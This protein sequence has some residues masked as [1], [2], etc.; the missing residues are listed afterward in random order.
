MMKESATPLLLKKGNITA[1]PILHHTVETAAA[2]C[3]AFKAVDP[4]CVA[5]EIAETMQEPIM[6][7]VER[8][9][10]ISVVIT[11][12]EQLSPLYYLCEPCDGIFEGLRCAMEYGRAA[13]CIDLDV[14]GYPDVHERVPDPYAITI[15]GL[16]KYWYAYRRYGDSRPSPLDERRELQMA[17]RLKE[18]SLRYERV[19]FVG[20]MAHVARVLELVERQAFP[21]LVPARREVAELC[22]LTEASCREVLPEGGYLPVAYEEARKSFLEG[23]ELPFPPDRWHHLLEL[24]SKAALPYTTKQGIAFPGYH[25]RNLTHFVRNYA[26]VSERLSPTLFQ[27]LTAAKSCV[28]HNYAY[29]VWCLATEYPHLRNVDNRA[30]ID[31]SAED[32]WGGSQKIFFHLRQKHPKSSFS[33]RWRREKGSHRFRLEKGTPGF[34]SFQPED[35]AIENFGEFLKKKGVQLVRQETERTLPFTTSLEDGIDMRETLRH[36]HERQLYVRVQGKPRGNVGSV[37]VIFDS[38]QGGEGEPYQEK[39]PWMTTW[40]GEHHQESDM[41]FYATSYGIDVVGPGICRCSY[42]GFMLSYPP[43]RVWDVW[44]DPDYQECSTKAE[45]LLTAAIDYALSPTVIYV[46]ATPPRSLLKSYARRYG[47]K[48]VYLPIGQLSTTTL[49]KLKTFHVLES[50][51]RRTIA[52]DYIF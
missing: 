34:C 22:T 24:Y 39:Y 14:D 11:Y 30:E 41:A 36:W 10:D 47:K 28:D 13:F 18:L 46:A 6:K 19:L 3:R 33:Q 43:Q 32:I 49:S 45:L 2:V 23:G 51:E 4:D 31:L 20:G 44:S 12:T 16:E 29:E 5:V 8:L 50:R 25:L 26:I 48:V 40:H 9:P 42:G 27:I 7:A 15:I 17:R 35:V 37:V 52:D 21:D 38:D 1:V